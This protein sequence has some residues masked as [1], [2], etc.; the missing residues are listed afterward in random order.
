MSVINNKLTCLALT[1]CVPVDVELS[2]VVLCR[3]KRGLSRQ[4]DRFH[5]QTTEQKIIIKH[6]EI[7]NSVT[8][9]WSKLST[10]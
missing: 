4:N 7:N 3:Y 6:E 5:R 10:I 8:R 1:D 2:W 9:W